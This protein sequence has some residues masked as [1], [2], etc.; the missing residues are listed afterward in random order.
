[1]G[2]GITVEKLDPLHDNLSSQT[3]RELHHNRNR[4]GAK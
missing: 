3:Y 2:N 1:M 4:S